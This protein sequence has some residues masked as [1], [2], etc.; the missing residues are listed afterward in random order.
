[1]PG[2]KT[3]RD[4]AREAG[5]SIAT[6]SYVLSQSRNVGPETRERVLEAARR[7]AYRP[8]VT[9][10]NLRASETRLFAY[11]WRPSPP[12]HFNPILD[13]FLQSA[14]DAASERG[15]RF[16]VFPTA[17]IEDEVA[18]YE[19]LMLEG[20]VDEPITERSVV[21]EPELIV[22]ASSEGLCRGPD[23]D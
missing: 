11:T 18:T 17:T 13:S 10:R 15:Y 16:L 22:R 3:I 2:A 5:V 4:V 7:L 6:V 14:V 9:A 19:T 12:D 20:Q 8:N 23:R 21:L 1:M